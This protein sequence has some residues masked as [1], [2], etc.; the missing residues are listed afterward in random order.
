VVPFCNVIILSFQSSTPVTVK[1][2]HT[3]F[4]QFCINVE[5][6]SCNI[7]NIFTLI[8]K[9][10]IKGYRQ[11]RALEIDCRYFTLSR[12][13]VLSRRSMVT[14]SSPE[15]TVNHNGV[16]PANPSAPRIS[17]ITNDAIIF[18]LAIII[19]FSLSLIR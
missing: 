10:Q 19:V 1:L 8:F 6:K 2:F 18:C 14:P 12:R 7:K 9:L 16:N 11:T 3:S 13:K 4:L 15:A 17:L 5:V